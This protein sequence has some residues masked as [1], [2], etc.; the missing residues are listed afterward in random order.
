ME[1]LTKPE[2]ARL[3]EIGQQC[4][5][6]RA[7]CGQSPGMTARL[8]AKGLVRTEGGKVAKIGR[9]VWHADAIITD[10]GLAALAGLPAPD[11]A[12]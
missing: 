12:P 8:I 2:M 6:G 3:V 5:R 11:A 7:N 1:K 4:R 10:S 9:I